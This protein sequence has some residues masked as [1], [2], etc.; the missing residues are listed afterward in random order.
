MS[1]SNTVRFV[2]ALIITGA[3]AALATPELAKKMPDGTTTIIAMALS[4]VLHKMNDKAPAA[5]DAVVQPEPAQPKP[6]DEHAPTLPSM[7]AA[8]PATPEPTDKPT[9]EGSGE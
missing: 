9:E 5:G 6:S 8:R 7:P 2:I 3:L 1:M 4:A